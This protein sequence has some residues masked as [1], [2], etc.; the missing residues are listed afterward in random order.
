MTLGMPVPLF[1][2]CKD[3]YQADLLGRM[4]F[5]FFYSLICLGNA[6]FRRIPHIL[7]I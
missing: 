5:S 4:R 3:L 6:S 1:S 2:L 7:S